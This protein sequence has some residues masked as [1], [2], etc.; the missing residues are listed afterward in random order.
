MIE[1]NKEYYFSQEDLENYYKIF[2]SLEDYLNSLSKKNALNDIINYGNLRFIYKTGF[3]RIV[4]FIKSY[5]YN[6]LRLIY[7]RQYNKEILR[8]LFMPYLRRAFSNINIYGY[9]N[10]KFSEIN[11]V[12]EQIYKIIFLKRLSFYGQVRQMLINQSLIENSNNK[13]DENVSTNNNSMSINK[14][15]NNKTEKDKDSSNIINKE[16]LLIFIKILNLFFKKYIFI[17]LFEYYVSL[18]NQINQNQN[19]NESQNENA[20]ANESN[21]SSQKYNTFIYES[22][23]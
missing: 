9:Y 17:R 14:E 20:I 8:Q 7:Q 5:P 23:S 3:E 18:V 13:I 10:Q 16:K 1:N 11:S 15:T 19:Q 22:F 21:Y 4:F 12:F 2:V 6:L